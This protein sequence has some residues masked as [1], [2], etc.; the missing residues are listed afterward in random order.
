MAPSTRTSRDVQE[1]NKAAARSMDRALGPLAPLHE[2]PILT[3]GLSSGTSGGMEA[4]DADRR[5]AAIGML[6]AAG[7]RHLG[8][9]DR[10]VHRVGSRA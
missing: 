7:D 8:E 5:R 9:I 6:R 1:A 10:R 3:V 2:R 4:D